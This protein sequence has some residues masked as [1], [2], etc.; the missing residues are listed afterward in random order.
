MRWRICSLSSIHASV[1]SRMCSTQACSRSAV[2]LSP[3]SAVPSA[4][5]PAGD[6]PATLMA[7]WTSLSDHASIDPGR[8]RSLILGLIPRSASVL[9]W[10][11]RRCSSKKPIAPGCTGSPG[12]HVAQFP[13][14]SLYQVTY[15][16]HADLLTPTPSTSRTD[17]KLSSNN[18][19]RVKH[20]AVA[21]PLGSVGSSWLGP[22]PQIEADDQ[23]A[24]TGRSGAVTGCWPGGECPAMESAAR[25]KRPG[26]IVMAKKIPVSIQLQPAADR[27]VRQPPR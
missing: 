20:R 19:R 13:V 22:H 3:A 25:G 21:D 24:R 2:N 16:Q 12:S 1:R 26:F 17:A 4:S 7:K 5:N 10:M 11:N 9:W 23:Q 27:L 15:D 18:P 14:N 6:C 8:S